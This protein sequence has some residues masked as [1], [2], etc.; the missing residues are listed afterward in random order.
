MK[1]MSI[2]NITYSLG[3]DP[4][5]FPLPLCVEWIGKDRWK[6]VSPFEYH[7][8]IGEVII[9][10]KDFITDFGSKPPIVWFWA[11]SPTDEAGPAYIIHDFLCV[12]PNYPRKDADKIFLE[13][14]TILKIP[15]WKRTIMYWAVRIWGCFKVMWRK[16]K[17]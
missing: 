8:D 14:M 12:Q 9:A 4:K 7:R 16:N 5:Y 1:Y 13:C 11:G 6:L 3:L 2:K 17:I 10:P 15:L